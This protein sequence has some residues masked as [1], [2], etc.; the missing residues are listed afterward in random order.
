MVT[1]LE[2]LQN[3][4]DALTRSEQKLADVVMDNY[5]VSGLGSITELA[6]RAGVSTPTVARL[7]QKLG[8]R[9]YAE[10]QGALRAELEAMVTGPVTKRE[11]WADTLP[12]EHVL[13]KF[14]QATSDNLRRTV[15]QTNPG[16]FDAFCDMLANADAQVFV[17]GG[18]LS[19][20]LAHYFYLHLQMIRSNVRE[21]ADHSGTW[22]HQMLDLKPG[23]LVVLFDVR[24][25]ENMTMLLAEM[26]H[27]RGADIVLF[28]DQWRSPIA[29]LARLTFAARIEVPSA[30]DSGM[31]VMF[32]LEA[33]I[34]ALQEKLWED[35]HSR[36][37]D[38]EHAF[39]RTRLF[40]KFT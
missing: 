6:E 13:N 33:T 27:E 35:V 22:P 32:L 4:R 21:F 2:R 28:T 9:G 39:D 38:L 1:V 40:R 25:Y 17:G 34:A 15:E 18:R 31:G 29:R 24:R 36:T 10:F 11:L 14:S 5:P 26:A 7:V 8:F 3:K 20:A 23:D 12:K 30:W 19:G 16:D 37:D